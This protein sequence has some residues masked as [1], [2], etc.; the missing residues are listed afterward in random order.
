MTG[1]TAGEVTFVLTALDLPTELRSRLLAASETGLALRDEEVDSL[2]ELI[3]DR[4]M[5]HGFDATYRPTEEGRTL[6]RLIDRL[7]ADNSSGI[8]PRARP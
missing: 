1:L 7:S 3:S 6:E 2:L 8:D 4:L 5:T